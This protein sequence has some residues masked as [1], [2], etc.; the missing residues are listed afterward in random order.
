MKK[1]IISFSSILLL[2]VISIFGKAQSGTPVQVLSFN[3]STNVGSP[4]PLPGTGGQGFTLYVNS[5]GSTFMQWQ[6]TLNK[7][8]LGQATETFYMKLIYRNQNNV[9]TDITATEQIFTSQ[10]NGG[11]YYFTK[12]NLPLS[13]SNLGGKIYL[14]YYTNFQGFP[15]SWQYS[16][17]Y[18][19]PTLNVVQPPTVYS[20][21]VQSGYFSRNNCGIGFEGSG[22]SYVVQANTYTS[23]ISQTDANQ[24]AE[25]DVRD[26]GQ[27]YANAN[28]TCTPIYVITPN[29]TGSANWGYEENIVW[30]PI[31]FQGSFV[32]IDVYESLDNG[33]SYVFYKNVTQSAPNNGI[34]VN[35][36]NTNLFSP[37]NGWGSLYYK[38]KITSL[39]SGISYYCNNAFGVTN[40]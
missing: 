6:C 31:H 27:A 24:K 30:Y 4:V 1:S 29:G 38:I 14:K 18:F 8:I 33:N 12:T 37:F 9:E 26:N 7:A 15:I 40:D 34:L 39:A 11:F 2:V 36:L 35:G 25:K 23:T 5:S 10:Y 16:S 3:L 32:K 20:N 13:S 28:G 21:T 19:V 17:I 22:V